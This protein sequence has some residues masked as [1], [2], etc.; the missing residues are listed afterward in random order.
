[1]PLFFLIA[2]GAGAFVVG[3]TTVDVVQDG[4]LGQSNQFAQAAP[5]QPFNPNAYPTLRECLDAATRQNVPTSVCQR[6]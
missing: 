6:Q 3:A 2:I 1:M 4:H 5:T